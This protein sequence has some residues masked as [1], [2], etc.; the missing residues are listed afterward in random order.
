MPVQSPP[1][2]ETRGRESDY[3]EKRTRIMDAAARVFMKKGFAGATNREIAREAG[4]TEG[5]IYWYFRSKAEL[6]AS[7]VERYSIV[8][9]VSDIISDVQDGRETEQLRRLGTAILEILSHE[10]RLGLFRLIIGECT[11]FPEEAEGFYRNVILKS[12]GAFEQYLKKGIEAGVFREVD[13]KVTAAA[14]LGL[15]T[16]Y[17]IQQR[18]LPGSKVYPVD[19]GRC[20]E[21]VLDLILNGLLVKAKDAE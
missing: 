10:D 1:R 6:F 19:P 13:V 7:A 16:M 17:V 11:K 14:V 18:I 5:L 21:S 9:L 20:V 15:F 4:I 12:T 2:R 3:E 8:E